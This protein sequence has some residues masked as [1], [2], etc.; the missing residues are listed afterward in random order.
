VCL[1]EGATAI[2]I[3]SVAHIQ[4]AHVMESKGLAI[5]PN[6]T[7]VG[8]ELDHCSALG[9]SFH[10]CP[11][12]NLTDRAQRCGLNLVVRIVVGENDA[13]E[14]IAGALNDNSGQC[15]RVR[16]AAATAYAN[17]AGVSA[18]GARKTEKSRKTDYAKNVGF[19]LRL[20][21]QAGEENAVTSGQ[22]PELIWIRIVACD[23]RGGAFCKWEVAWADVTTLADSAP[24]PKWRIAEGDIAS[25]QLTE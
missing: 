25:I 11:A 13:I 8:A 18:W 7:F 15:G 14:G 17:F 20:P 22:D 6:R 1:I 23:E 12:Q 9:A 16:P 4:S 5:R 3:L 21:R 10:A 24:T 2:S 19:V